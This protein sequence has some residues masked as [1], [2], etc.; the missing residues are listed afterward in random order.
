MINVHIYT[1]G[2]AVK[3]V[4]SSGKT[5]IHSANREVGVS[6]PFETKLDAH[7]S[8]ADLIL[9]ALTT[10]ISIEV[11]TVVIF[12]YSIIGVKKIAYS[13]IIIGYTIDL[14]NSYCYI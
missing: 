5:S 6:N 10:M 1:A 4:W 12:S 8:T 13:T 14:T 2:S 9:Q 7:L 11:E 3:L